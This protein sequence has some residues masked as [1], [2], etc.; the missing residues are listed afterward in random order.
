MRRNG[1]DTGTTFVPEVSRETHT[2]TAIQTASSAEVNYM[3]FF[4]IQ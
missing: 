2:Y 3:H 4:V 1:K